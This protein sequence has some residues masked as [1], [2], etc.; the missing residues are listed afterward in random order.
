MNRAGTETEVK[1]RIGDVAALRRRLRQLGLR[2]RAPRSLEQ[3][4]LFDSPSR[5]LR[6]QGRMLRL[7]RIGGRQFLTFKGPAA[8]SKRYKM[9]TEVETEVAHT[10]AVAAI[11]GELGFRP[12]FRYEKYRHR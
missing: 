10:D 12:V 4:V 5:A 9:R 1:L 2:I 7:R 3:N 11:L 8:A 6:R